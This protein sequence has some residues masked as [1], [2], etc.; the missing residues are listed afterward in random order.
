[1]LIIFFFLLHTYTVCN[2]QLSVKA[3]LNARNFS[4][5]HIYC[6]IV[7]LKL[8]HTFGHPIATCCNILDGVGS[9]LEIVKFFG[10]HFA[11]LFDVA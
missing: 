1:M 7:A 4:T 8:L 10:Q 3:R 5:Q 6:N 2:E 11:S 9:S